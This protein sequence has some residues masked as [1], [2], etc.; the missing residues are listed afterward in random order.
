MQQL[1]SDFK[2]K[3]NWKKYQSEVTLQVPNPYLDYLIDSNFQGVNGLFVLLFENTADRIVHT[4]D[5]YIQYIQY[6]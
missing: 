6:I 3:I 1:K 5:T 2:G 4:L